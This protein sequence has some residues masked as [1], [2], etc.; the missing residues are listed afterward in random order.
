MHLRRHL[1]KNKVP[2]KINYNVHQ[3]C[4][5]GSIMS[6]SKCTSLIMTKK[7]VILK[8][9]NL[10]GLHLFSIT[11]NRDTEM[12]EIYNI[13]IYDCIRLLNPLP[14]VLKTLVCITTS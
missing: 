9:S 6:L 4:K 5:T 1:Q 8:Y 12:Q 11:S 2:T 13:Y 14:T 3:F 7:V 10:K